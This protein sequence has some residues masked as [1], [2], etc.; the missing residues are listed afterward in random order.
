MALSND[1]ARQFAKVTNTKERPKSESTVYGTAVSYDGA[2]YVR[3]DGSDLLTPVEST[4]S[5]KPGERVTVLIKNH[6]AIVTGNM[7]DP[8]ASSIVVGGVSNK[9]DSVAGKVSNFET[10]M[11]DEI[12]VDDLTA[13]TATIGNLKAI[14]AEIGSLE[15]INAAIENLEAKYADIEYVNADTI[16]ALNAEIENLEVMFADIEDL[17][18]SQL[19]AVSAYIGQLKGYNAEFTYVS[20]ENLKAVKAEVKELDVEKLDAKEADIKYAN[21]NFANIGE[22]AIEKLFADSGIIKDLVMSDGH[23]TGQLVGV[24]IIGDIIEGGTVKADKLVV[25]GEDGLY[26]KLNVNAETVSG[27]QTEYNSLS[28]TIITAKSITAEKVAVDDLVA[29][30]ATIG[31]FKITNKSIYS[32]IKKSADNTTRGVYLDKEGQVAF[33]DSDNY[34]RYFRDQNGNYKLEISAESIILGNTKKSIE[35]TLNDIEVGVVNLIR[36]S[37]NMIFSDYYFEET[38]DSEFE[39]LVDD[40]GNM[41]LDEYDD[42]AIE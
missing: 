16:K 25:L 41:L 24:T 39:Y 11:A 38:D 17:D 5:M 20:A 10:I 6:S 29:F 42:F 28:G 3:V 13:I 31:G 32:G 2:M 22:A 30:D 37:T 21:I 26:Y 14:T 1:L 15:A 33:G 35:E 36:N 18:V 23:V 9:V 27:E 40:L 34:L 4:V 12:T 19:E 7:S 8:S